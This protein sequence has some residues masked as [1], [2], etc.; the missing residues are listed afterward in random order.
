MHRRVPQPRLVRNIR[1]T[2]QVKTAVDLEAASRAGIPFDAVG[3]GF[4]HLEALKAHAPA[5]AFA[6]MD[7]LVRLWS[8]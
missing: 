8:T 6:H 2:I 1:L 3:W 5:E 4:T 7:D